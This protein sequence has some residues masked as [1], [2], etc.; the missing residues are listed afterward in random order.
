[1][2]QLARQYHAYIVAGSALLPINAFGYQSA[3]FRP[4]NKTY[5]I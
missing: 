1:M 3:A 4:L 5:L 2:S